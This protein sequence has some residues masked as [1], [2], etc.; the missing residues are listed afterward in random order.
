MI[1]KV[2]VVEDDLE[3]A[4]LIRMSL[5]SHGYEVKSVYDGESAL[6]AYSEWEPEVILL[7]I[8]LPKMNGF[9]VCRKIR[10]LE[11]SHHYTP[12]IL[13]TA[14]VTIEDKDKG[15]K[16]GADDYITKPH[17]RDE[18]FL[19]ID[20]QLR[21]SRMLRSIANADI[22]SGFRFLEGAIPTLH[23]PVKNPRISVIVPTLNEA[24][25]LPHVLP[26]IP[27]WVD[28]VLLVD[29]HSIDD[30]VETARQLLPSIRVVF[31]P[32]KGKGNALRYGFEQALGDIVVAIDADGSTDPAEIPAFV[33]TLLAGADYAKGTRFLQGAGTTDMPMYRKVGNRIF[34]TIVK[35]LFGNRYSDLLYGYNA[36]W[37]SVLPL[38][39]LQSDGFEIET[40]MNIRALLAGLKIAEVPSFES[41]RI[42]GDAKLIAMYDGWR[43]LKQ[44]IKEYYRAIKGG[45]HPANFDLLRRFQ[46][47]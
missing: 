37:K 15:F 14:L 42:G 23:K 12:I 40:E 34:V 19:R 1:G 22:L 26:R 4:N 7:D 6:Q 29:G 43:I 36:F 24:Q 32:G 33:G 5:I 30:T 21:R 46:Q 20:C 17:S 18:L 28:E 10:K 41:D 47:R 13:L 27:T 44:I 9:E 25:C 8:M 11:E 2:L 35:I 45:Y 16:S 38:M 39:Q 3:M 31:Q